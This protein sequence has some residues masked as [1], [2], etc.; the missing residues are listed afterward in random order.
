MVDFVH[1]VEIVVGTH[2]VF[3]HHPAHGR[4]VAFVIVLLQTER[5]V[6]RNLQEIRDVGADAIIHLLPEI[7]VMRIKR[8]VEIEDPG[9]D[10]AETARRLSGQCWHGITVP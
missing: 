10:I 6:L 3:G 4:A 8:V 2:A 1:E 7:E 9:L 5:L